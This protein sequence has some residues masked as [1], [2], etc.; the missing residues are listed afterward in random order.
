MK[1][2]MRKVLDYGTFESTGDVYP[3]SVILVDNDIGWLEV[4]VQQAAF[5]RDFRQQRL[6]TL[7]QETVGGHR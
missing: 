2:E 1:K 4:A 7:E 6:D 3:Y 5:Y